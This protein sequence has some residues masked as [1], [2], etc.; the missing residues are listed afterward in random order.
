MHNL[1]EKFTDICDYWIVIN[2]SGTPYTFIAEGEGK[3]ELIIHNNLI[4]QQI[5]N[6]ANEKK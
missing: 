4:W 2:N 5:K 1:T 6:Q 3:T